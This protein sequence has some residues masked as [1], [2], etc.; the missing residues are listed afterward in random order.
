MEKGKDR[1][2]ASIDGSEEVWSA[3]LASTLTHIAVFVPLLFL[4]GVS[5]IMFKQLSIV[6]MFSLS[7][8]LFVAV[9]IVPVLCSRLLKLPPPAEQQGPHRPPLH[10]QRAACSNGMDDGYRRIL[11]NALHH[12]P[13]VLGLGTALVVAAVLILPTIGYELMPVADEGEV[14]VTAELPV[15]TRI[16][17]AQDVAVRLESLIKEP[18]PRKKPS[19]PRRA[20]AAGSAVAAAVAAAAAPAQRRSGWSEGRARPARAKTSR[21]T[22]TAS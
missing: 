10:G 2:Q 16:E 9:T 12:R 19:S 7:M 1:M 8:S 6:V 22:S 3:I 4:S 13:T 21:A 20:A 14:S 11:H 5:S 17:R 15:G 18:C